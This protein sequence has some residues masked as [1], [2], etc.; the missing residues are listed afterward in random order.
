MV[1]GLFTSAGVIDPEIVP[2]ELTRIGFG[3]LSLIAP[4]P[5][6]TRARI[7]SAPIVSR[8]WPA[9]GC[10]LAPATG[11]TSAVRTRMGISACS[12]GCDGGGVT[13]TSTVA[14]CPGFRVMY[15]G[16]IET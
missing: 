14:D 1:I 11:M 9:R 15:D 12:P 7:V 10:K 16:V 4:G 2:E 5:L 8:C 3:A 6:V 13:R